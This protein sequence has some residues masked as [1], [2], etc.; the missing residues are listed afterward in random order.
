MK[1]E[2][3]GLG[4]Y[5]ETKDRDTEH[6][7]MGYGK[8][9]QHWQTRS[10][11]IAIQLICSHK[12]KSGNESKD[13][14]V[15]DVGAGTGVLARRLY[16]CQLVQPADYVGVEG[17]ENLH[18]EFKDEA[19]QLGLTWLHEEYTPGAHVADI[20]LAVGVFATYPEPMEFLR[21]LWMDTRELLIVSF[22]AISS[23]SRLATFTS[24]DMDA[25]IGDLKGSNRVEKFTGHEYLFGVHR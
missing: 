24:G 4:L 6:E 13:R 14:T 3:K 25:Y 2:L 5:Q 8:D 21:N 23:K 18:A 11:D 20:V 15:L 19:A 7:R 9:F 12:F 16:N 1:D 17:T 10:H 22:L